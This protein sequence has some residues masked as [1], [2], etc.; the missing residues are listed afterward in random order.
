MIRT[1]HPAPDRGIILV[2]VLVALALGAA[3]VVVMLTSQDNLIDRARRMAAMAQA[4]ALALGGETSVLTALS[5]DMLTAPEADH[6]GESW[7]VIQQAAVEIGTGRFSLTIRD[8]QAG[9]DLN[10]LSAGGV[11]QTQILERLVQALDL[12]PETTLRIVTAVTRAGPLHAISEITD[13]DPAT[14]RT[15]APY[16]SFL[17][18]G[19]AVNLNSADPVLIG[20][21]LRNRAAALRLAALRDKNG[22]VTPADLRDLG[23]LNAGGA[24]FKSA[25]F[26]VTV[27]AE[28]DDVTVTLT[29][30]IQRVQ[31]LGI[32]DVRIIAR[33]FG[34]VDD[35]G[36]MPAVPEGIGGL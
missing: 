3:L 4:Q 11:A 19:G 33:H 26:D 1:T 24:G 34:P 18:A 36:E 5:A 8:A 32:S 13:L 22:F 15:L 29:S 20:V 30:R 6:F 17:P 2:N 31:G 27:T 14:R 21:L 12:P 35:F 25:V 16:V 23:L 9:F 28:V 7:A 10:G